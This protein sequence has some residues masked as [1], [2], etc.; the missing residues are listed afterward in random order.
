MGEVRGPETVAS[1]VRGVAQA[2]QNRSPASAGVPQFGQMTPSGV[3]QPTQ[4]LR[5][6]LFSVPQFGQ[7]AVAVSSVIPRRVAQGRVRARIEAWHD[8]LRNRA[9]RWA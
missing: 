7:I 8:P 6:G 3:A 1:S 2:P 9:T 5:S 4:N